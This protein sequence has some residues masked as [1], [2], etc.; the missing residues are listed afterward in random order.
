M[1]NLNAGGLTGSRSVSEVWKQ[2]PHPT[3]ITKNP[4]TSATQHECGNCT[5]VHT[6]GR[7]SCPAKGSTY[8]G[9]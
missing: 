3:N 6:P 7:A 4:T 8:K 5:K 9:Y 1:D 2:C